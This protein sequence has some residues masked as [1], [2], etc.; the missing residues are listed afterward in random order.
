MQQFKL[1]ILIKLDFASWGLCI[2]LIDDQYLYYNLVKRGVCSLG[3]VSDFVS[4]ISTSESALLVAYG[5]DESNC[6]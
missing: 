4:S 1:N 3:E 2:F 6:S 5:K